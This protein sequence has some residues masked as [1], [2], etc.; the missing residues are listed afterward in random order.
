MGNEDVISLNGIN[1]KH[2]LKVVCGVGTGLG[3]SMVVPNLVG[4]R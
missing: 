3:M 1:P 2:G 4:K